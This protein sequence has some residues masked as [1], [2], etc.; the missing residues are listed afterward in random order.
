MSK[1]DE[2]LCQFLEQGKAVVMAIILSD[3]GSTPRSTGTRM[4]IRSADECYGTIGGGLLEAEVIREGTRVLQTKQ[5]QMMSYSLDPDGKAQDVDA[6]CGGT[7][8]V[9]V[10]YID[11]SDHNKNVFRGVVHATIKGE[12]N[13]LI[14]ELGNDDEGMIS[15]ERFTLKEDGSMI[16]DQRFDETILTGLRSFGTGSRL[17]GM[18]TLQNRRFFVECCL[19]PSAVYIFGAGHVGQAVAQIAQL[20]DF[21]VVVFDDRETY[22]NRARFSDADDIRVIDNFEDALQKLDLDSSGYVV[23]VTRGHRHDQTVLRQALKTR[24]GYIGMIG[25]RRKRDT[26]Y[27]S[28]LDEGFTQQ[29]LN[30]V[31]SPIGI[32]IGAQTPQE[33]AVSIVAELIARRAELTAVV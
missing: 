26:I 14:R 3:T 5:T 28:L 20:V 13:L 33:I 10:E 31:H 24:A 29:D 11:D 27:K 8:D 25:S 15:V 4:I 19:V 9:L 23:I 32:D 21:R 12:K 1:L 17:P 18:I 30:R 22:A 2:R 7:L 6:I 16:G